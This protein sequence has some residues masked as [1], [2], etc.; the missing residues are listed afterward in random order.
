ML[1]PDRNPGR[2]F[3][4]LFILSLNCVAFLHVNFHMINLQVEKGKENI[5]LPFFNF[6]FNGMVP[7]LIISFSIPEKDK[8]VL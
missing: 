8:R 5:F 6:F 1:K 7:N 3:F 4:R 2:M